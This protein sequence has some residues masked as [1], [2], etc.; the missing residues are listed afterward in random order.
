MNVVIISPCFWFFALIYLKYRA[1]HTSIDCFYCW[2][3]YWIAR[4]LI[5]FSLVFNISWLYF[6][7]RR[8]KWNTFEI[9][10]EIMILLPYKQVHIHTIFSSSLELQCMGAVMRICNS[11]DDVHDNSLFLTS[12]SFVSQFNVPIESIRLMHTRCIYIY[13][14]GTWAA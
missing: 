9:I 10:W 14:F 3:C 8:V 1:I 11:N 2:H 6:S 7:F 12:K 5:R 4:T 13:M